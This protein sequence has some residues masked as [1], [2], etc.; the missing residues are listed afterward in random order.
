MAKRA[1]GHATHPQVGALDWNTHVT[2]AKATWQALKNYGDGVKHWTMPLRFKDL[3]NE[4]TGIEAKMKTQKAKL[5]R[6]I[7]S[8]QEWDNQADSK[9]AVLEKK[10]KDARDK[11]S[12]VLRGVGI[13]APLAKVVGELI[14][15]MYDPEHHFSL[16]HLCSPGPGV[17][18][19]DWKLYFQTPLYLPVATE[20]VNPWQAEASAHFTENMNAWLSLANGKIADAVECGKDNWHGVM[21][22]ETAYS[23]WPWGAVP[24]VIT[25]AKKIKPLFHVQR[26]YLADFRGCVNPDHFQRQAL[27]ALVGELC[28]VA[29]DPHFAREHKNDLDVFLRDGHHAILESYPRFFLKPGDTVVLPL[30]W[31]ALVVAVTTLADGSLQIRKCKKGAKRFADEYACWMV[32]MAF[33]AVFD[34]AHAPET[35]AQALA[36]WVSNLNWVPASLRASEEIAKWRETLEKAEPLTDE[37]AKDAVLASTAA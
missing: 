27:I 37:P 23:H 4:F 19:V 8:F 22:D 20:V 16:A 17:G 30:G 6:Y 12:T 28:V 31:Q 10:W 36:H 18:D 3:L 21:G 1:A 26:Q 35:Q 2:S 15:S 29:V 34:S 33:D 32:H 14:Q 11:F 25:P 5:S 9:N 24:G 13:A 7:T